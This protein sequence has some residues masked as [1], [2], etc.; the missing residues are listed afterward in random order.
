MSM[1]ILNEHKRMSHYLQHLVIKVSIVLFTFEFISFPANDSSKLPRILNIKLY[2]S[3][4]TKCRVE[5]SFFFLFCNYLY[6]LFD[7]RGKYR[8]MV[9]TDWKIL[10]ESSCKLWR[11]F[12]QRLD[13][14]KKSLWC[15]WAKGIARIRDNLE[16]FL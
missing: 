13:L 3:N 8:T 15:L 7:I 6:G 9:K 5:R 11:F 10:R 16:I 4:R 12:I 1:T 14:A 2:N